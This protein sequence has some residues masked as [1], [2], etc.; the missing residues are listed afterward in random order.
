MRWLR[1][2]HQHPKFKGKEK[3][4]MEI[5]RNNYEAYFIDYLEGNLDERL[6]DSFIEFLQKNPDLKQELALYEPVAAMPETITFNKKNILKKEKYDSEKIFNQAAISSLEGDISKNEKQEFE[7]Y[8]AHH[9][10]K[11][12]QVALFSKTILQADESV[13]FNK[14]NTLYKKA[15]GKTILLW[16]GRVAALLIL[17]IAFFSLFE[18]PTP[19]VI[20]ENQLAS[21]ENKAEKKVMVVDEKRNAVDK[22]PISDNNKTTNVTTQPAKEI[23]LSR[24]KVIENSHQT[25]KNTLETTD[26]IV[27]RLPAKIQEEI[28]TISASINIQKTEATLGTMYL[29]FPENYYDEEWLL[30]NKMKEKLNINKITKAGL[31]L[32]TSISN[33]RFT[34]QTDKNGKVTEYNYDS[35]L[36]AFSIPCKKAE[37]E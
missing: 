21:I 3:R 36:L 14:K 29:I 10:E 23:A 33:E 4:K 25:T 37:T 8:L 35:R 20:L 28:K 11:Q 12:K 24:E 19:E 18:K 16:T 15:I 26:L 9:H 17:A 5:S 34:Y 7:K 1:K 6:V 30:A 32:F 2:S 22:L 27:A 31:N 13:T